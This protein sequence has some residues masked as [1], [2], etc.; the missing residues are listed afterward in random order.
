M[1][2]P[3]ETSMIDTTKPTRRKFLKIAG[4]GFILA[5]V[6]SGGFLATRTPHKALAPWRETLEPS[7]NDDPRRVALSFAILA[8]NPHNRQPWIVNL[9]GKDTVDLYCDLDRRL[10]HT[11]PYDRQITI[12]LGCFLEVLE[13]AANAHGWKLD[14]D[15]LPAGESFPRLDE[16]PVARIRFVSEPGLAKD[17]LYGQILSRRS[18]KQELDTSK[19]VPEALTSEIIGSA[20]Y[21][22]IQGKVTDMARVE[23]MRKLTWDAL[24]LEMRTHRT[25]KE[26]VDLM[27]V[28]KSEIEANPDGID[29][30]GAFL[31]SLSLIGQLDPQD[32]LDTESSGFS[33]SMS[34]I[35]PPMLSAMGYVYLKT[36][37]NT[38]ADQIAAGRDYV[39]FNLKA[40]ELGVA[41]RPVSQ[42]LQEY[43]EIQPYYEAI[44]E[45]LGIAGGET[46]QMLSYIGYGA[47]PD[48]SPRWPYETRIRGA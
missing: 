38:R 12:G 24:E 5:A 6:A 37:G 23:S 3:S 20:K 31:E 15:E 48:P 11:D 21:L 27:R 10:P 42:A 18:N 44:R 33:M 40:T 46:L 39:R 19:P 17:P 2:T 16:R 34:V 4:G 41:M 29:L 30:G 7:L 8:P 9:V 25:A 43:E 22:T 1:S 47:R 26:S 13:L 32:M 28:G 35:K 14:I 45:E 36:D